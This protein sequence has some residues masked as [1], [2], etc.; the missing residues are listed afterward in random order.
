MMFLNLSFIRG[1]L[2]GLLERQ[3][4]NWRNTIGWKLRFSILCIFSFLAFYMFLPVSFVSASQLIW[5]INNPFEPA[6]ALLLLIIGF[7]SV[8]GLGLS[9]C[10][11][12]IYQ[13][14][15]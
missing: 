1:M 15:V 11:A 5:L 12:K 4:V 9:I 10:S 3:A 6:S 14:L 8:L 7:G 2:G 13:T